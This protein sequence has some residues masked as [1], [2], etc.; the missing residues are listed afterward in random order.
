METKHS[1]L[2]SR[3][4]AS[5][6]EVCRCLQPFRWTCLVRSAAFGNP[7][8]HALARSRKQDAIFVA[9]E[10]LHFGLLHSLPCASFELPKLSSVLAPSEVTSPAQA[11]PVKFQALR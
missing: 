1:W 8:H 5:Q 2:D 6:N 9:D 10:L 7:N 4:A 3:H 11:Q